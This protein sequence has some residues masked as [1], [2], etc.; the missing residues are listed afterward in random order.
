MTDQKFSGNST[1][2]VELELRVSVLAVSNLFPCWRQNC[3][4]TN[5]VVKEL[6]F[7][8]SRSGCRVRQLS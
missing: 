1:G 7:T 3:S 5:E 4:V 2:Y 6:S 8:S